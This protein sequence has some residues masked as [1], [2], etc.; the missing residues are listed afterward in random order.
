MPTNSPTAEPPFDLSVR[1]RDIVLTWPKSRPLESYVSELA[2]AERERMVINY[3][4]ASFPTWNDQEAWWDHGALCFGGYGSDSPRCYMVHDG[5]VRGWCEIVYC[6]ARED[7]EVDGWPAGKYIVRDPTW[8]PIEPFPME[9]FRGYRWAP[10][11]LT[12]RG[13]DA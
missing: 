5:A 12:S 7:G 2:R 3:R 9:G 1:P 4:V 11:D 10:A 6:C 13:R 8:H